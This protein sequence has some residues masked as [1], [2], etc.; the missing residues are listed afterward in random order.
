MAVEK[1]IAALD[2]SGAV[3]AELAEKRASAAPATVPAS[4]SAD[5]VIRLQTPS[6]TTP[7][8]QNAPVGVSATAAPSGVRWTRVAG[9]GITGLSLVGAGV[10]TWLA[11]D[12]QRLDRQ[13]VEPGRRASDSSELT[14]RASG[15]RRAAVAFGIGSGALL[16][17]GV[18][19]ALWPTDHAPTR[20]AWNIRITGNGVAVSARY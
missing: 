9:L 19:L 17:T 11:L 6:M 3:R 4:K 16:V 8:P 13:A 7:S 10:T 18:V 12:A 2:P 15:R 1:K 20:T 5:S 14:D